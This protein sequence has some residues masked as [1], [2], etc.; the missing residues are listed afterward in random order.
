MSKLHELALQAAVNRPS[1][2]LMFV[3]SLQLLG[4]LY[5]G[6][7]YPDTATWVLV[8]SMSFG[9]FFLS[10]GMA[11]LFYGKRK[12]EQRQDYAPRVK[13]TKRQRAACGVFS[14]RTL[15]TE[16]V[17]IHCDA[18]RA[19][20]VNPD[21]LLCRLTASRYNLGSTQGLVKLVAV[22]GVLYIESLIPTDE[23][24]LEV[25]PNG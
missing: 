13:I 17:K 1:L 3:G 20:L 22:D 23:T 6:A 4:V 19:L 11:L 12:E 14:R 21:E 5:T 18:D 24:R 15:W 7:K 16:A 25:V 8:A 10:I 2:I 9:F